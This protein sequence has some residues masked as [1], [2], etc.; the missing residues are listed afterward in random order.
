MLLWSLY[1]E[2]CEMILANKTSLF[3]VDF[4]EQAASISWPSSTAPQAVA[5]TRSWWKSSLN[6]TAEF[7]TA[8]TCFIW[9][10]SG[11]FSVPG[12]CSKPLSAKHSSKYS[13]KLKI[14][15][16]EIYNLFKL[17][18][19]STYKSKTFHSDDS[20]YQESRERVALR[21]HIQLEPK[22]LSELVAKSF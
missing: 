18:V 19:N 5:A 11:M 8:F 7:Q 14:F 9:I 6:W 17:V 13:A 1:K 15:A 12:I 2:Y 16:L 4:S 20:H 3:F 10:S 21:D 22:T